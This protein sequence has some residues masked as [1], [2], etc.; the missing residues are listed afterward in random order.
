M[1]PIPKD[2][3][4]K[5]FSNCRVSPDYLG[6]CGSLQLPEQSSAEDSLIP[7]P[8]AIPQTLELVLQNS[9]EQL[10][11]QA[12]ADGIFAEAADPNINLSDRAICLL[13]IL[14]DL[15][16]RADGREALFR[17]KPKRNPSR[18]VIRKSVIAAPLQI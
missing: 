18:V 13:E 4:W 11:H 8:V 9:E 12:P 2:P 1:S 17:V 15:G 6:Q 10:S 7:E 16:I 5:F 3:V 14:L